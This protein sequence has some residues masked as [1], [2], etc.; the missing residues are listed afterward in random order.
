M[1]IAVKFRSSNGIQNTKRNTV[2]F[3]FEIIIFN[4]EFNNKSDL[5]FKILSDTHS[6]NQG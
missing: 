5:T 2:Y 4:G 1:N 3:K 6:M